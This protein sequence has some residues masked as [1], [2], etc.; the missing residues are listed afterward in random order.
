MTAISSA[1]DAIKSQLATSFPTATLIPNP[2][3]IESASSLLLAN[4]YGIILGPGTNPQTELS[5][6]IR[7]NREFA[8][9]L[10]KQITT[11]EHN[12]ASIATIEKQIF[13]DQLT[14]ITA[15]DRNSLSGTV[16]DIHF[17]S[18]NGLELLATDGEFGRFYVLTSVFEVTYLQSLA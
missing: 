3:L 5:C 1:Y 15:F 17:V 11:T 13:E 2:L 18:D 9:V 14:L 6:Q 8:I 16:S 10:T 7:L 12:D 4:G